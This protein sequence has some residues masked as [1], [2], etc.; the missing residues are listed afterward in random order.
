LALGGHRLSATHNIQLGV[1]GRGRRDVREEAHGVLE[2]VGGWRPI[3][4]GNKFDAKKISNKKIHFD[5]RRPPVNEF[6]HNNQPKTGA[7]NGGE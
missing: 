6:T 3:V 5:L 2:C 1:G 7:D 4:G